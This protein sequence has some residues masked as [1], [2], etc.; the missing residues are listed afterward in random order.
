MAPYSKFA[1]FAV[2]ALLP[3]ASAQT[4]SSCN[5]IETTGC[6]ADAGLNTTSFS[7]DFTTISGTSFPGWNTTA[8]TVTAS[9]NGAEFTIKKRGDAPTIQTDFYILFGQID[10]K[11]KAAPGTGIVS[12]VVLESDDLDEIDWEALGGDTTQIETDYFGKGD[13]GTYDRATYATVTTPQSVYHTYTVHWTASSIEWL[14]DGTNVRTL[15]YADAKNGTR[16]PQTPCRVKIG[17]W[18]GGDPSNGEGTIEWAGGET[19]YTKAP[20]TMYVESVNITNYTPA[21]EYTYDGTSGSWE[22]IK[23]SNSTSSDDIGETTS[24][25]GSTSSKSSSSSTTSDK[26][27]TSSSSSSASSSGS[28]S[29]GSASSTTKSSDNSSKSVSGSASS[30]AAGSGATTQA[31]SSSGASSSSSASTTDSAGMSVKPGIG[32][33][34]FM[35]F[36]GFFFASVILV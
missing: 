26:S 9:E 8:G 12:S 34:S 28:S 10:V 33:G 36:I 22:S 31:A 5:P 2:A 13:T 1:A 25:D 21:S 27:S 35:G 32:F 19:D 3:F 4:Y 17:I 20:F 24:G 11:F 18:A 14:I 30:T 16:F 6:P 29:S 23:A 15:L 7:T